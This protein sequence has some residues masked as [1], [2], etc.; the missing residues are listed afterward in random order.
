MN[1]IKQV[2]SFVMEVILIVLLVNALVLVMGF[3][4]APLW[5]AGPPAWWAVNRLAVGLFLWLL[6]LSA[7]LMLGWLLWSP[8]PTTTE[9]ASQS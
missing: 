9:D 7:V 6:P 2:L 4:L 1:A 5:L 3:F 8:D